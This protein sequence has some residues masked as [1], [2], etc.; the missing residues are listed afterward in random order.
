MKPSFLLWSAALLSLP[1]LHAQRSG[2][3]I[4]QVLSD[5]DRAANN[6]YLDNH[7]RDHFNAVA[8]E[9]QEFDR[10]A[11]QGN[12]DKDRLD[13][14][15]EN[16]DHIAH[17]DRVSP[18]DREI[19]QQDLGSLRS[20]R[21]TRGGGYNSAEPGYRTNGY[22]APPIT[23]RVVQDLNRTAANRRL[24]EHERKHIDSALRG[25][26]EFDRRLAEG[27]FDKDR[28]D[29]I[30]ENINHLA[31]ADRVRGRDRDILLDDLNALRDYRA[32]RGRY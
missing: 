9:L 29:H 24:D 32:T 10:R 5:I 18:Q 4:D 21:A 7:E 3:M 22:Q 19:L 6:A 14:A 28:L 20:F 23:F 15:I 17:A 26:E 31:N 25:L 1:A 11:G 16:L 27:N 8:R 13:K 30:I 12:F 2:S